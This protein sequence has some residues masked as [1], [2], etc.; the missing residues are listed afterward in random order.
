MIVGVV[1]E[2]YPGERRVALVPGVMSALAKAGIEV[3]VEMGAGEASGYTDDS[4]REEGAKIESDR[5]AVLRGCDILCQIRALGANPEQGV[6]DLEHLRSGTTVIGMCE[7]LTDVAPLEKMASAGLQTFA[8]ELIPRI[9]RAQSM[10]VLSSQAT[11]AGYAAVLLGAEHLPKMFP[12]MMTAAGT[13]TPAKVLIIGVG[14]AG[15]Q[16]ISTARRLG[17]VVSGYDIRPAVK[18]Q[19]ESLGAKFVELDIEAGGSEDK[20]GYAKAMGEAFY[21]K[22]QELMGAVV[23][24]QDVVITTA[25]VPGKKAP[26]L[27]TEVMVK[28]MSPSSVIVDLAAERGGNCACTESGEIVTKH[29]VTI[30]GRTNL[31]AMMPQ[32]ASQMFAKNTLTF[33]QEHME[34][35]A[36][37][38]DLDN[39]VTA[40]T[41]ITRD[42]EIVHRQVREI[43]NLPR[44]ARNSG[45]EAA[46]DTSTET[47]EEQPAS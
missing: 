3:I 26:I 43:F 9:T 38:I 2:T 19:V 28:G 40:G 36:L 15:L 16:A 6:A 22:Q 41:L 24:D 31:P 34:D 18:E 45:N 21:R 29:G 33:L 5:S 14:V 37:K 39:E 4:Y 23:A 32:H 8:L 35:G 12:M 25:A 20:G 10:D 17:A 13:L 42:G 1:R 27:V 44:L 47:P 46:P 30:I 11:I 7:P